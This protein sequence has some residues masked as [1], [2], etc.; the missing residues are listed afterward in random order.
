M[1]AGQIGLVMAAI[2][3][4]LLAGSLL[5]V[6]MP[7][8]IGYGRALVG[9]SLVAN[10]AMQFVALVHGNG[11]LS[12]AALATIY[13]VF[14]ALGSA[15]NVTMLTI[16]Q[17]STPPEMLGR[18]A[19]SIRFVAQ[20]TSPLGALFGGAVAAV[21]GLRAGVAITA[22]AFMFAAL[23]LVLSPLRRIGRTL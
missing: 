19:A 10:T 3:P 18:V 20:G 8:R 2:G 11:W 7:P 6:V 17:V 12:V 15:N 9:S 23:A 21:F 5:A 4:G 13:F 22:G 16:R 14:T 1:S